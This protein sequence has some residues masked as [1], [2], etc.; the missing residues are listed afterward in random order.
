MLSLAEEVP[1][2]ASVNPCLCHHFTKKVV[3]C[4]LQVSRHCLSAAV[5]ADTSRGQEVNRP[6]KNGGILLPP[7]EA[8][9]CIDFLS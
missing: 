6:T 3:L 8:E 1:C 2:R 5:M 7:V 4:I 9:A